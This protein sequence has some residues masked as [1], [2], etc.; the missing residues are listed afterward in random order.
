LHLLGPL[1]D[2]VK[3]GATVVGVALEAY[4]DRIA[5]TAAR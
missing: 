1:E 4:R 3:A 2:S 5:R